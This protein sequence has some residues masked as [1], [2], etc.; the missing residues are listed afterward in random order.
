M[1]DERLKYAAN[2]IIGDKMVAIGSDHAYLPIYAI[3][4][5]IVKSAICGEVV[6]GPYRSTMK[7]IDVY[8]M[9]DK[10]DARLG[11]GL[12]V[13]SKEDEVDTITICGMGGPLIASIIEEGY[14]NVSGR[15]RLV[16]QANNFTHPIRKAV[17]DL[18]YTI[19]HEKVLKTGKRYYE[20]MVCDYKEEKVSLT[21]K[22]MTFGPV[23][24]TVR[25]EA[26]IGKVEWEHDHM[27]KIYNGI[28]SEK[29]SDKKEEIKSKIKM[30]EEVLNDED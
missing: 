29:S 27:V 23:N 28:N 1:I 4:N 8:H 20:I 7:N 17:T 16:L 6:E 5:E 9:A 2:Y 22:E 12:K 24:L 18:N 14:S 3:Q 30:L 25:D 21:D 10:I 11:D 13:L 15:P 19:T 26:F